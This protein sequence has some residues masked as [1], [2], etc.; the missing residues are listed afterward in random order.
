[1]FRAMLEQIVRNIGS[2]QA[3]AA[4]TL[5]WKLRQMEID[6]SLHPTLVTWAHNIQLIGNAAAHNDPLDHV[7]DEDA[8]SLA[9]LSRYFLDVVYETPAKISRSQP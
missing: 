2:A 3:N 8:T 5:S 7:T 9:D 4:S 6:H 1:M